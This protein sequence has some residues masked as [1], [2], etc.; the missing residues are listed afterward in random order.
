MLERARYVLVK[1]SDAN[2]NHDGDDDGGGSGDDD[3]VGRPA[4]M[5]LQASKRLY[6]RHAIA[7]RWRRM[8]GNSLYT[9]SWV[10]AR[11]FPLVFLSGVLAAHARLLVSDLNDDNDDDDDGDCDDDGGEYGDDDTARAVKVSW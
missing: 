4:A 8:R 6:A 11:F 9:I 1:V 3:S 10:Y 2:V 7:L 5:T